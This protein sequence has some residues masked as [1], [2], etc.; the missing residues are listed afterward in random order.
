MDKPDFKNYSLEELYQVR[1]DIDA[2]L[3][4]QRLMQVV[5]QIE[6]KEKEAARH[7]KVKDAEHARD[8]QLRLAYEQQIVSVNI[9]LL[10][11][12]TVLTIGGA[13]TGLTMILPGLFQVDHIFNQI[14]TLMFAGLYLAGIWITVRLLEKPTR[15]YLQ[16]TYYFWLIQVPIFMSPILGYQYSL[17][18]F[19]NVFYSTDVG[20]Q[21]G[22]SAGSIYNLSLLQFERPWAMGIN[23]VAAVIAY[24]V[25]HTLEKS[26]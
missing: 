25:F 6:I 11:I 2:D 24:A 20:F 8:Q 1:K 3:Y 17:G 15:Q 14:I 26:D 9:W 18:L 12:L 13:F 4:P 7:Q 21:V 19:M 10:R 23:L 22:I 16:Y 5:E